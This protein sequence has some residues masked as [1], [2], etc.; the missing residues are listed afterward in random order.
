MIQR[1][2]V[3]LRK[4]EVKFDGKLD[5]VIMSTVLARISISSYRPRLL[6]RLMAKHIKRLTPSLLKGGRTGFDM[7]EYRGDKVLW[8]VTTILINDACE[9]IRANTSLLG[10]LRLWFDSTGKKRAADMLEAILGRIDRVLGFEKVKEVIA[11]LFKPLILPSVIAGMEFLNRAQSPVI[12]SLPTLLVHASRFSTERRPAAFRDLLTASE[13][14][15]KHGS[16]ND[17]SATQ[18]RPGRR[19]H[20]SNPETSRSRRTCCDKSPLAV[21]GGRMR[22]AAQTETRQVLLIAFS[23]ATPGGK[24]SDQGSDRE[25]SADHVRL[26]SPGDAQSLSDDEPLSTDQG[27]AS[28]SA[29][30]VQ[31]DIAS[32][33]ARAF[34]QL[35]TCIQ[36]PSAFDH[37][38]LDTNTCD[39]VERRLG[40]ELLSY[41]I[42]VGLEEGAWT[43]EYLSA[44]AASVLGEALTSDE[45][46][47]ELARALDLPVRSRETKAATQVAVMLARASRHKSVEYICE[48]VIKFYA[49]VMQ[50]ALRLARP[51]V[52]V[53][54]SAPPE[55]A[56]QHII[57]VVAL[58]NAGH[59]FDSGLR[60]MEAV[61]ST[62]E[63]ASEG[64]FTLDCLNRS[65]LG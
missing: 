63:S 31:E 38:G 53:C 8:V 11:D 27:R 58:H 9:F 61:L 35:R 64:L 50:E 5:Y 14:T 44:C 4:V 55:E 34:G 22:T 47:T 6:L 56:R 12:T 36:I 37:T 16:Q 24:R 21:A 60:P 29:S 48:A 52:S 40:K 59:D 43:G 15:H 2:S 30:Q 13:D 42:S 18:T 25:R 54:T 62:H 51:L 57:D 10:C 46:M 45:V 17:N 41:G 20:A 39:G 49:P 33:S 26:L 19:C 23:T 7:L 28:S 32:A 65:R 3:E 1:L